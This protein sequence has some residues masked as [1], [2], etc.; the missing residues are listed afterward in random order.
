MFNK[1]FLWGASTASYQIEGAAFEDGKGLNVWD[2]FSNEE[3]N[4]TEGHTGNVAC[5]HY[6]RYKEDVAIMKKLGFK[7]YRFSFS[8]TRILP[9]GTGEI[10]EKG[11]EFYNNLIDEL[12]KNGIEPCVTIHHWDYP[13]ELKKRGGWLNPD[14]PKWFAEFAKILVENFSDRVKI[15]MTFNEPQCL[16]GQSFMKLGPL[17]YYSL[18]ESLLAAHN[19]LLAHGYAVKEMRSHT[20]QPL[21]IGFA[22]Q[23][24][25]AYPHTPTPEN[26]R[27]AKE[28][29]FN[30]NDTPIFDNVWW[31]EPIF[32]GCYPESG[33][34]KYGDAVPKIGPDDMKIISQP[35]DFY[36][37]N[38]Y[39][40]RPVVMGEDGKPKEIKRHVG[41]PENA[42]LWPEDF[43]AFYYGLKAF[44]E[45]YN[46][47]ILITESGT[48]LCDWISADGKV[49]DPN[50]ID[51]YTRH[52]KN[53]QRAYDDGVEIMGYLAWSFMDNFE[54]RSGYT[55]RFG[56]VYVDYPTQKRVIKDSAYWYSKV[57]SGEIDL[58]ND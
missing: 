31:T 38:V 44:Y 2:V 10:N 58:K 49:H 40:G 53:V 29:M 33:L 25:I 35:L 5:D 21:K 55:K 14:S 47:P 34:E 32:N 18:R 13:Y 37:V 12:L 22:P 42:C 52:L 30:V 43:D 4:I 26:I 9:N 41:H 36:G 39:G 1:D 20:K 23:G 6:H 56:L 8:W 57:I 7:A 51:Y 50:R 11:I 3:N 19:V 24:H 46:L 54:W 17:G 15:W 27:A 45:R 28:W 48:P 16:V